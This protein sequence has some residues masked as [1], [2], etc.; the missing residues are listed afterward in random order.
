MNIDL[1]HGIRLY[2]NKS[3]AKALKEFDEDTLVCKIINKYIDLIN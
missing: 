1:S 3:Y 2:K